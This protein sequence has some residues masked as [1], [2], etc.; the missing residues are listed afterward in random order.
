MIWLVGLMMVLMGLLMLWAFSATLI[1]I[2][3]GLITSALLWHL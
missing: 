2:A 1:S 3:A